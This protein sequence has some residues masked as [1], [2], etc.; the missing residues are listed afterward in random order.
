MVTG[1]INQSEV[2]YRQYENYT[3]KVGDTLWGI[4]EKLLGSGTEYTKIKSLNNLNSDVI[5]KG[6]ILKI[7]K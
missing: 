2:S 1:W 7:P 5:Y 6:Q 4:A 3:V